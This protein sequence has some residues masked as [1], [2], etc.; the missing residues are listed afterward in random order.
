MRSGACV[1]VRSPRQIFDSLDL[2]PVLVRAS[3]L[4]GSRVVALVS[5][6]EIFSTETFFESAFV[7]KKLVK[8]VGHLEA[9]SRRPIDL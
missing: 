9:A 8:I 7:S 2:L 4:G 6:A 3:D 1:E 5:V